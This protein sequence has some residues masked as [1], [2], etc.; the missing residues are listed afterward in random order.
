MDYT[1]LNEVTTTIIAVI[2]RA[3]DDAR[4]WTDVKVLPELLKNSNEGIGFYLY[5]VQESSHYKNLPPPGKDI[6]PV[7]YTPMAL[8]LFYQ[9]SPNKR[10]TGDLEDALNEQLLMSVAMK[11][12]HDHP[13]ITRTLPSPPEYP[14]GKEINIKITL[15]TLS[16]SESVQY[17]AAAESP[18]RLSAYYEVSVV[19]L[20]P[21]KPKRRAG[22]VL[23]YGTYIFTE[24]TPRILRS[25]SRI[26][27]AL[28][29]ETSVQE[30]TLEPAEASPGNNIRFFGTGFAGDRTE[31]LITNRNWSV[32]VVATGLWNV[33]FNGPD[34]L[35]ATVQETASLKLL[36]ISE[37][38]ASR[39]FH[40]TI[41][42]GGGVG[43]NAIVIRWTPSAGAGGDI[44]LPPTYAIGTP[45]PVADG[46]SLAFSAGNLITGLSFSVPV[47]ASGIGPVGL[48]PG[49]IGG[50]TV[51]PSVTQV[52]LLPGIYGAQ[53]NV[54]RSVTLSD[55]T[56]RE[57]QN[58]SNQ[59]PI[60]ITPRID[61]IVT[62]VSHVGSLWTLGS[63]ATIQGFIFRD[64]LS[65]TDKLKDL[66][67]QVI[68]G[69]NALL[70]VGPAVTLQDYQFK[71]TAP[72]TLELKL[73]VGLTRVPLQVMVSG[74]ESA[75]AWI[76]VV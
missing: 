29:G 41:A 42:T 10:K 49:G 11:A 25:Q 39:V 33:R 40:F 57:I 73:P 36:G 27:F 43:S 58:L 4:F 47:Q 28:P 74:A 34:Q 30:I 6:P 7:G 53:V 22:R 44:H 26:T 2:Q 62:A 59:F 52:T 14:L 61:N 72:A 75:P 19:F 70:K 24:G 3:V 16:P 23:S 45:V 48:P 67:V 46:L 15:Q 54:I 56:T 51:T 63:D 38:S 31:L 37:S 50:S 20:V 69:G 13:V 65:P 1:T 60:T 17:W 9:L 64:P 8:N 71:I 76:T 55:G 21:E 66:D 32:P 68:V 12:L 35:M 5:H 18:V